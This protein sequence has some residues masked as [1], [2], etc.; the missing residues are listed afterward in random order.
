MPQPNC[1]TAGSATG[2]VSAVAVEERQVIAY[3]RGE[4][5]GQGQPRVPLAAVYPKEGTLNSDNP[6]AILHGSWTTPATR[7]AAA[8]FLAYLQSPEGQRRLQARGYRD[9]TGH[10]GNDFGE[11]QGVLAD[12]PLKTVTPP[13]STVLAALLAGWSQI[14]KPVRVLVVVDVSGSM[15]EYVT[16][17]NYTKLQLVQAA[18]GGALD[19]VGD[20]D[21]VGLWTFSDRHREVVPIGRLGDQRGALKEAVMG[22]RAQGGTLLYKTV[23]DAL[24]ALTS[25][26]DPGHISALV[27]LT[28]GEDNASKDGSLQTLANAESSQP[29]ASAVR[30]FTIAYGTDANRSVLSRMA[31]P[32]GGSSY[33]ASDPTLIRQV[34]NAILSSF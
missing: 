16:S 32:S 22:M 29:P 28:D 31:T 3:N 26:S 13:P 15:D 4:I 2:Y 27:V 24:D 17:T 5:G 8:Q 20:D 25:K 1:D 18:L 9:A 33:D 34:F 23:I 11:P 30:V 10:L 14:R 19:Q 21:E 7:Q 6:F 12:H